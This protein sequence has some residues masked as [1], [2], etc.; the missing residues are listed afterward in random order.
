MYDPEHGTFV[1]G[2]LAPGG[3]FGVLELPAQRFTVFRAADGA[4]IEIP[5][6]TVGV[7]DSRAG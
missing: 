4:K 1:H 6:L 2:S 5:R 3:T 7:T